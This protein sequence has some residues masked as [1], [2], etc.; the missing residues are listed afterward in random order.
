[1]DAPRDPRFFPRSVAGM[2]DVLLG[3]DV[4]EL[5]GQRKEDPRLLNFSGSNGIHGLAHHRLHERP[6]R[7]TPLPPHTV[8]PRRLD[9][10]LCTRHTASIGKEH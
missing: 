10:R 8:L 4:D 2:D 1:M 9:C 5:H 3:G 6:L 7:R